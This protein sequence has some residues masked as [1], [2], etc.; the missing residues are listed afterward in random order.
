MPS[1]GLGVSS[2]PLSG[3]ALPVGDVQ[4]PPTP[5]ALWNCL[6]LFPRV[7]RWAVRRELELLSRC[8]WKVEI[9]L[10]LSGKH[11]PGCGFFILGT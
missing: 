8:I 5:L 2:Y 4:L 3:A 9:L 11:N 6:L 10:P 7:K 1:I